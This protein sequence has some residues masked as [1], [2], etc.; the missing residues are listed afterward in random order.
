VSLLLV[1]E[2]DRPTPDQIVNHAFFKLGYI[3][4]KLDTKCT[5]TVP[6][7]PKIRPPTASTIRRGY[8]EEWHE[9]CKTS[10]VGEY[11]PGKTF[12]ATGNRRNKTVAR[13]C[14]KEIES[15]KQP[16]IP[17][18]KD[19]VYLPFPARTHWPFQVT[20]GLSEIPE[21]KESSQEGQALVETNGNDRVTGRPP[22]NARREEFVPPLKENKALIKEAE[23]TRQV[24]RAP[25]RMRSVRKLSNPGRVTAATA[26]AVPLRVPRESRTIQ[27]TKSVKEVVREIEGPV[28]EVQPL[29][30]VKSAAG[31]SVESK[32]ASAAHPPV[33]K[34]T[35][36]LRVIGPDVP[37]SDPVSV[38]ARL[39]T[40]RDNIERAL[41]R[42]SS[43]SERNKTHQLPFVSKWVDYS[44]K[45]GVGFVLEDGTV[46]CLVVATSKHPVTTATVYNGR[47]HLL[48]VA[49]EPENM[50]QSIAQVP[51]AYYAA[52]AE[53]K[54]ITHIEVTE[55]HRQE[56]L[57]MVWQRFGKYMC[58]QLGGDE[59]P[60]KRTPR[61]DN[62]VRFYQR[63]GNVGI[64]G[65]GDGSFQVRETV[66]RRYRTN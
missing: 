51:I 19:T 18:A 32:L 9:M 25:T 24:E 17:F 13:D 42:K 66:A 30:I 8:T 47:T 2:D 34:A 14:Q 39:N 11:E 52:P 53:V 59:R 20:G 10:A 26:T 63:L 41:Q 62:F 4:L 55:R 22:R 40:F 1:H 23:T 16:N 58:L 54:P 45:H 29:R 56:H 43:R 49:K 33:T 5:S 64:W 61:Q 48:K 12:G 38:L 44:R 31:K 15:G 37:S 6:K 60:S 57:Q 65:F 35:A 27:R 46:G 36:P 28:P 21:E 50:A 3:P 7:W